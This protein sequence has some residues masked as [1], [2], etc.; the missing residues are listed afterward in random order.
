MWI[1][2][3]PLHLSEILL[4]KFQGVKI[5]KVNGRE[6][7]KTLQ[8]VEEQ[9]DAR[10]KIHTLISTQEHKTI[11]PQKTQEIRHDANINCTIVSHNIK[12]NTNIAAS[13]TSNIQNMQLDQTSINA[14]R[15]DPLSSNDEDFEAQVQ[16]PKKK[17]IQTQTDNRTENRTNA[18][19]QGKKTTRGNKLYTMKHKGYPLQ[20]KIWNFFMRVQSIAMMWEIWTT[21]VLHVEH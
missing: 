17:T 12:H 9:K 20:G 4:G 8:D 16:T 10:E 7:K 18:S 3:A 15:K 6:R 1:S 5:T 14:E 21:F 11:Y 19:I 2:L 13:N